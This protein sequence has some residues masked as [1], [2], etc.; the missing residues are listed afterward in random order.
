MN[1]GGRFDEKPDVVIDLPQLESGFKLRLCDLNG[2]GI[3]D[4][5]ATSESTAVLLVSQQGK[6]EYRAQT[7]QTT[8]VANIAC[9]DFT[10]R[11]RIDCIL[12]GRF[13]NNFQVLTQAPDGQFRPG[14]QYTT[15]SLYFDMECVDVNGDGRPDVLLSN[16][17]IFLRRPDGALP[18]APS[19]QLRRPGTG[20]TY[21]A[22]G[23][24][25]GDKRPDVLLLSQSPD[26]EKV[27]RLGVFYN[28]GDAAKPFTVEPSAVMDLP[29]ERG[30][31]RDGPT[32][33]DFNGD[34]VADVVLAGGQSREAIILLGEA[35]LGLD[36]KRKVVVPL[37]FSLHHDT[38]LGLADFTGDGK[39]D[40]AAFGTS[41]TGAA[42][43]Y[44]RRQ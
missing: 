12:G 23:D 36:L 41:T 28:T 37:D 26:G 39:A 32:V 9:G 25:N 5:L 13:I 6:L 21:M 31:L 7:I 22:V 33:G 3:A 40:L 1:K 16:G 44:I 15:G 27:A 17:D 4:F 2:D 38:K 8:R 29:L 43:V 18:D 11:G 14:R 30:L 24:F 34:G 35:G 42:G 10:G 19:L 20:W